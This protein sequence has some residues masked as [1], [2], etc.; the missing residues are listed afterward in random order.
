MASRTKNAA[1][2]IIFG[3]VLKIYQIIVPFIMRTA[4]IYFMGVEYL[5]LNS[6]FTSILQVL[7]LAELGV[8][9]AMVFSMYKPIA[10]DDTDSI[11]ALM[12]LY[13]VYYRIIGAV[14]AILGLAL[15]PFIPRLIQ[16]DIPANINL[17]LLYFLNLAATV[18][19]Y[20][21]FA[22]K[23]AILQAEQR[24]DIFSKVGLVV[25]TLQYLVQFFSLWILKNYYIYVLVVLICQV[26]TNIITAIVADKLY[27]QYKP[28]GNMTKEKVDL[29]NKRIADLF[30]AQ[31]GYVVNTSVDSVV[32][33]AFLGLTQLAIYNN[34]FFIMNSVMGFI[35][36]VFNSIIAGIGNSL[37]LESKE[38]N[39]N[40][41]KKLTFI[42]F[43]I[44]NFCSCCFLCIYQSFMDIW[45]G[46][47]LMLTFMHVVLITILFYV[48]TTKKVWVVFKDSAGIWHEDR[49]RPL[50]TAGCNLIMNIIMVKYFE[51]YGVMLSTILAEILISTPW[52]LSNLFKYVLPVEHGRYY[53][54]IMKYVFIAVLCAVM[55]V[56]ICS[57][58]DLSKS[59][60]IIVS[61]IICTVISN[62]MQILF[63]FNT[64]EFNESK[65]LVLRAINRG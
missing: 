41:L 46:R 6:L 8:G 19:S 5:G 42:I 37:V 16:G 15:T 20:W 26:F 60:N 50:I 38:K 14:I 28:Y 17:Y 2:N 33:S 32:I 21:M 62:G 35:L 24:S 48:Q 13:K 65:Q 22:Y 30:T 29:I 10:E 49:Y 39:Y 64:A 51:L 58:I 59:L 1:R 40:D 3:T 23:N 44:T 34:Y 27:P 43:W 18:A 36:I 12:R 45:V 9:T 11:C 7:S 55:S 31:L 63:Y 56:E 25:S 54:S 53:S 52:L 4:M 57:K 61:L 47:E